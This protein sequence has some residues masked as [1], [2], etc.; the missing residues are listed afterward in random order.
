MEQNSCLTVARRLR[1]KDEP[2]REIYPLSQV[3]FLLLKQNAQ[4]WRRKGLYSSQFL[5]LWAHNCLAPEKGG[6]WQVDTAVHGERKVA[7]QASSLMITALCVPYI[8]SRLSRWVMLTHLILVPLILAHTMNQS[9]TT[10]S[11]YNHIWRSLT[12]D[13]MRLWETSKHQT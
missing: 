11:R 1:K 6:T 9:S 5:E 12:Y 13:C 4:S 7:K 3:V 2:G 8:L 10:H